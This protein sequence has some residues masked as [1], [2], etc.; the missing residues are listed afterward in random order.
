MPSCRHS[1]S[2]HP[3]PAHLP[4]RNLFLASDTEARFA[5]T[6]RRLLSGSKAGGKDGPRERPARAEDVVRLYDT[7][8]ANGEGAGGATSAARSGRTAPLVL[9]HVIRWRRC[10]GTCTLRM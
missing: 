8:I 2:L 3:T 5:R 7:L 9:L 6:Q 10:S 4:Q 1:P